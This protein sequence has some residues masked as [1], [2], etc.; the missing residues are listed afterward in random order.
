[1]FAVRL[2]SNRMLDLYL[3][4]ILWSN[5]LSEPVAYPLFASFAA[6][7]SGEHPAR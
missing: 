1:M 4:V 6:R 2:T 5:R 7:S 3:V